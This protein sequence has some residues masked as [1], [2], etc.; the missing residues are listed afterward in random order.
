MALLANARVC[1][2]QKP[3]EKPMN[4][5]RSGSIVL[6]C[7]FGASLAAHAAEAD[8]PPEVAA[9]VPES[10]PIQVPVTGTLDNGGTF[11]GTL[12]V[13]ELAVD[14]TG[15]L[16]A[17]G[18]LTGTAILDGE[19]VEVSQTVDP[20]DIGLRAL[21]GCNI[22][23]LDLGAIHLDLLGLNVNLAPVALDVTAQPGGGLLGD[24]LCAVAGLLNN[25]F[26]ALG[27]LIGGAVA[28]IVGAINGILGGIG[29]LLGGL[30]G[31]AG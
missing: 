16:V 23:D 10:G 25:P 13:Q 22:L 26:G 4:I 18:T 8:A 7:L 30:G 29:G 19:P 11:E 27:G 6:A 15:R 28:G 9:Q 21:N 31:I 2:A 12:T 20:T 1:F 3:Q 14:N 5:A 24:L 17:S